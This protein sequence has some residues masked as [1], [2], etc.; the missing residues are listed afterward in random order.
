MDGENDA[1]AVIE[2]IGYPY[3]TGG[4]EYH[5]SESLYELARKNKVGSAYVRAL[6]DAGELNGLE[7]QWQNR[8]E[9]QDRIERTLA[10]LP[11]SIPESYKYALVKSQ[12]DFWA[13]SKDV[14]LILFN[15][16]LSELKEDLVEAGY[17]FCGDSPT[18][19]DVLDP[20]TDIQLDVQSEFSL[21]QV[22]YFDPESMAE[23]VQYRTVGGTRLPVVSKP[24]DLALIIIHSVTEQLFIF[25]EYFAAVHALESF[26]K[27]ELGRFFDV[28]EANNIGPACRSFFTLV[29]ALTEEVFD[30]QTRFMNAV[31]ERYP[32]RLAE[33][34]ALV[35][36]DFTTPHRYTR[37]TGL[38]TI[39][40]KAQSPRFLM[41]VARQAPGLVRPSRFTHIAKNLLARREREHYVHDTSDF[42]DGAEV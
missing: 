14:D 29:D 27:R 10:R 22:V 38:R 12:H 18:S 20:E 24:D 39:A 36:S 34:E 16:E 25:K 32:P 19:F 4:R 21:Q 35:E 31:L 33:R 37:G 23:G 13:D 30:C 28:V 8:V 17:E 11:E 15:S 9:F 1:K 41:S 5:A 7:K 2:T 3:E 26:S 6:H 42:E 40:G